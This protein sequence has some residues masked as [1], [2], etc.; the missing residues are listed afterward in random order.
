MNNKITCDCGVS[1]RAK[2]KSRHEKSKGHINFIN[3]PTDDLY[4]DESVVVSSVGDEDPLNDLNRDAYEQMI[5]NE[6]TRLQQQKIQEKLNKENE[7]LMKKVKKVK[8]DVS[9][10]SND[11]F[12]GKPTEILG[13]D[14]RLLLAKVRNY[15]ALFPDELK[16]FKIKKTPSVEDL[17]NALAEMDAI[18]NTSGVQT[19]VMDG[20]LQSLK[21]IEG[22]SS[23]TSYNVSGLSDILRNNIQFHSLSKQLFLKYGTYSRVEPEYQMMFLI[24]TSCYICRQRNLSRHQMNSYLDEPANIQQQN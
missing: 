24:F 2:D 1:Y 20:I 3:K 4:E 11:L 17:E 14:K 21:V 8:D 12:S 7:K 5:Q 6:E 23:H 9:V 10:I 22:A 16:A 15:K 18:I 19:F 13:K